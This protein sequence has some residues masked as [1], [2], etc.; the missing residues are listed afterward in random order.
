MGQSPLDTQVFGMKSGREKRQGGEEGI[1][2]ERALL[3]KFYVRQSR[4]RQ[5]AE[6]EDEQETR[7]TKTK[8][9]K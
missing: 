9:G 6:I 8:R 1:E 2:S 5:F 4:G 3:S 7:E